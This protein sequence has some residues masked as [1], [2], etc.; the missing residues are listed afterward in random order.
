MQSKINFLAGPQEPLLATVK[1]RKLA[2]FGHVTRHDS[3]SKTTFR[4][5]LEGGLH[6][7]WQ[8]KCWMDNIIDW[9]PLPLSEV[10][11]MASCRKDWKRFSAESSVMSS[12]DPIGQ[13]TELNWI[14][15]LSLHTTHCSKHYA[16]LTLDIKITKDDSGY[17]GKQHLDPA[18][19]RW[20]ILLN[21]NRTL[22]IKLIGD[23]I[24]YY[25]NDH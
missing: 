23:R 20:F 10:L 12:D 4:G 21:G 18:N 11:T 5:T 7:G 6:C 9:T 24:A 2:W 17:Q 8:R 14:E 15:P 25:W 16:P 19:T 1:R 22:T 13:G 3:L